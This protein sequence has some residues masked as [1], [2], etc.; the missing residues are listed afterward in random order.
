MHA[1]PLMSM[2]E[3][4]RAKP[5]FVKPAWR[6]SLQSTKNSIDLV[7]L[8]SLRVPAEIRE[9]VHFQLAGNKIKCL[10]WTPDILHVHT[11]THILSK[12]GKNNAYNKVSSV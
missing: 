9:V 3:I 2:E 7:R 5:S 1:R 4:A 10:F 12:E 8:A 6:A 11:S